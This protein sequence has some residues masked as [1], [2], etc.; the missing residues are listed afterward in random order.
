MNKVS[1][2]LEGC[3]LF[4]YLGKKQLSFLAVWQ[5]A[6]TRS[7]RLL[8]EILNI[9]VSSS[10]FIAHILINLWVPLAQLI[11]TGRSNLCNPMAPAQGFSSFGGSSAVKKHQERK[12]I[13]TVLLHHS[14][15]ADDWNVGSNV[16]AIWIYIDRYLLRNELFSKQCVEGNL[17][18]QWEEGSV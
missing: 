2:Y 8:L 3:L 16:S 13:R 14:L 4:W 15:S 12:T 11:F 9:S 18:V 7:A 1:F 17:F 5:C 10:G 6:V